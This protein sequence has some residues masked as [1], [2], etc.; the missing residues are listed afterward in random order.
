[1][2]KINLKTQVPLT[3]TWITGILV[4]IFAGF[5]P[6]GKLA[7]L[8]SIGTLFT[9][10]TVSLGVAVLRVTRPELIRGFRTPWVPLIP[11]LAIIFCIYLMIQLSAF[12]WTGFV[13]WLAIGL[14]IYISYGFRNR[15]LNPKNQIK[16]EG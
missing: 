12:T 14:V 3:G 1:M 2:S 15:R 13:V 6:L 9:F 11:A 8:T 4:A 10:A 16:N 7:E 5:V